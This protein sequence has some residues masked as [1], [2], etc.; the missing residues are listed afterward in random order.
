VS[1]HK[2]LREVQRY[3]EAADQARM[4]RSAMETVAGTFSA[5]VTRRNRFLARD[6]GAATV[7]R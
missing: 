2:S 4:A 7:A 6:F 5:P 3:T 1:G